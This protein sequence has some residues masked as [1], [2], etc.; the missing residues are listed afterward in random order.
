MTLTEAQLKNKDKTIWIH[1][2]IRF[3]KPKKG[4][5]RKLWEKLRNGLQSR[6][7]IKKR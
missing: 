4:R 5:M 2:S 1:P 3:D 6:N 7:I